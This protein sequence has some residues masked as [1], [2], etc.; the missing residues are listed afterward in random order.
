MTEPLKQLKDSRILERNIA[1]HERGKNLLIETFL[2]PNGVIAGRI[3][4]GVSQHRF[5]KPHFAVDRVLKFEDIR[6]GD[7]GV[8]F[9]RADNID[10]GQRNGAWHIIQPLHHILGVEPKLGPDGKPTSF[11]R[12]TVEAPGFNRD[13]DDWADGDTEGQRELM[14]GQNYWRPYQR[15]VWL[16]L[17]WGT[18]DGYPTGLGDAI[19]RELITDGTV[20]KA[21]VVTRNGN[22]PVDDLWGA[23]GGTITLVNETYVAQR[24]DAPGWDNGITGA[25]FT[26]YPPINLENFEGQGDKIPDMPNQEGGGKPRPQPGDSGEGEGDGGQP[27]GDGKPEEEEIP[28]MPGEAG[29]DATDAAKKLDHYKQQGWWG[30]QTG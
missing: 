16:P 27:G 20:L 9:Q 14:L 29:Y 19:K 12:V 17:G 21:A 15:H 8:W 28:P 26:L 18:E 30:S 13:H 1:A 25:Y 23:L 2:A 3:P 22:G 5:L 24:A 6:A 11:W 10:D 4:E 7:E